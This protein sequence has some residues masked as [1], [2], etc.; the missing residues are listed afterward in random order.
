MAF[1][2][3]KKGLESNDGTSFPNSFYDFE[4]PRRTAI[5]TAILNA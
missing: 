3:Q 2:G 5:A 1:E 4:F